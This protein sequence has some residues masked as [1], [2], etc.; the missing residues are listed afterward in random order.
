MGS[1]ERFGEGEMSEGILSSGRV[2][3]VSEL[4]GGLFY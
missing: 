1:V 4:A 2:N 3:A